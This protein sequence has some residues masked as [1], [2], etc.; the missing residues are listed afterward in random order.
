MKFVKVIFVYL[1]ILT[2]FVEIISG[3]NVPIVVN[4][5]AYTNATAKAWDVVN[6]QQRS[7][8]SDIE[9]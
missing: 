2:T 7:A 5:W 4:T 3:K 6:R 9:S 1:F 8:V